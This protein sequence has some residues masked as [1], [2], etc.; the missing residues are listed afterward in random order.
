[1]TVNN[2]CFRCGQMLLEDTGSKVSPESAYSNFNTTVWLC[3]S[4]QETIY[5][6]SAKGVEDEFRN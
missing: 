1:M 4:C 5:V 2:D 3:H 6:H